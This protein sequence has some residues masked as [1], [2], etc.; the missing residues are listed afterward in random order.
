MKT[1]VSYSDDRHGVIIGF[2]DV[3]WSFAVAVEPD[4]YPEVPLR[5]LLR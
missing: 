1:W 3:T 5:R 4:S 2:E